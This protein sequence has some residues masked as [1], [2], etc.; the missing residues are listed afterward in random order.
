MMTEKKLRNSEF[1]NFEEYEKELKAFQLYFLEQGPQGPYRRVMMLEFCQRALNDAAEYFVRKISSDFEIQ[2]TLS[3]DE[4]KKFESQVAEL[5]EEH[6]K[7]SE[8]LSFK[9]RSLESARAELAAKEEAL[10]ESLQ[11]VSVEK[12]STEKALKD[13]LEEE[14]RTSQ[15]TIEDLKDKLVQE[16]DKAKAAEHKMISFESEFEKQKALFEQK[17]VHLEKNLEETKAKEKDYV[18]EVNNVKK[19]HAAQI[20]EVNEKHEATLQQMQKKLEDTN[21]RLLETEGKLSETEQNYEMIKVERDEEKESYTTRHSEYEKTVADL[22]AQIDHINQK[23]KE[24]LKAIEQ[25]FD[26]EKLTMKKRISELEVEAKSLEEHLKTQKVKT[27]KDEAV[28]KQKLEFYELQLAEG[29]NQL[30]ETKRAHEMAIKALETKEK[31]AAD[32]AETAQKIEALKA[33]HQ[34]ELKDLEETFATE[35]ATLMAQA[36]QLNEKISDLELKVK[37]QEND[38]EQEKELLTEQIKSLEIANTKITNQN[39]ALEQQKVRLIEESEK[40]YKEIIANLE[41]QLEENTKKAQDEIHDLQAR[42]EESLAQLRNFYELEKERLENRVIEEKEKVERRYAQQL[43]ECEIKM[44]EEQQMHMEEIEMLQNDLKEC[45]I[46]HQAIIAQLEQ[47]NTLLK[48]KLE[49][50]DLQIKEV[51]EQSAK[52]QAINNSALEQQLNNFAEERKDLLDKIEKLTKAAT[53][54]EKQVTNLE[55]KVEGLKAEIE[56]K[57]KSIEEWKREK[58]EEKNALVERLENLKVKNQQISDEYMQKKLEFNKETALATQHVTSFVHQF[59]QAEYQASKIKELQV[60]NEELIA[61][62]EEKLQTQKTEFTTQF[63]ELAEKSKSEKEVTEQKYEQKRKALKELEVSVAKQTAKLERE[64]AIILEKCSVAEAKK[65][66]LEKTHSEE[67]AVLQEQLAQL[68]EALKSDKNGSALE[69]EKLRKHQTDL[70]KELLEVQTNYEKDK[71]LWLGKFQFLEQQRDQYKA[72]LT[73]A[74]KKFEATLEELHKRE[75][76]EKERYE[77][78]KSS[79]LASL[80]QKTKDQIKE[81]NET[82]QQRCQELLTKNKQLEKEVR[83]LSERAQLDYK[84]KIAEQGTLEKKVA[85]L[86]DSQERLVAEL[87]AVKAERDRKILDYQKQMEKDKENYKSKLQDTETRLKESETKRSMFL[88]EHERE[89]TRWAIEKDHLLTQKS[90]AQLTIEKLEK[91]KES[92]MLENEKLKSQ[93]TRKPLYAGGLVNGTAGYPTR[94]SA[95]KFKENCTKY[96]GIEDKQQ[97]SIETGSNSSSNVKFPL[98]KSEG[99]TTGTVSAPMAPKQTQ[100]PLQSIIIVICLTITTQAVDCNYQ[101]YVKQRVYMLQY[102][103]GINKYNQYEVGESFQQESNSYFWHSFIWKIHSSQCT[104]TKQSLCPFQSCS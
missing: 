64:K 76:A 9:L 98:A 65:Q 31:N 94:Y 25:R 44:K 70:E 101:L 90:E 68:K 99:E 67:V 36:E 82:H 47:E 61:K 60:Q 2:K 92:L 38:K 63:K 11:A 34:K 43:E 48:Q 58:T 77:T 28:I 32:R 4:I 49:T 81:L 78:A 42:S 6:K 97:E 53:V 18:A 39:K 7:D 20:K 14:R 57:E 46:Q 85:E 51:K 66:E 103:G 55:N 1:E 21:E 93:R 40:H 10:K 19:A 23:A 22:R 12:E 37:L 17:I 26:G 50:Q 56:R 69:C 3:Q 41:E 83:Q 72:D 84:G 96:S 87:E 88:L 91:K 5:R 73:E 54:K 86:A 62:Y 15:K 30:E 45:E 13:Q 8:T 95:L 33:E 75:A 74:Q 80:E 29:K 71:G 102:K 27:E 104:Y 16:Q 79:A 35:K 59:S 89:K 52:L 100:L 24:D